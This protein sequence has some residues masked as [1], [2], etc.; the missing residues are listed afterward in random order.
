MRYQATAL[1]PPVGG[2]LVV[3][4]AQ[5]TL[6]MDIRPACDLKVRAFGPC[7]DAIAIT[8]SFIDFQEL[9]KNSRSEDGDTMAWMMPC[10]AIRP[11]GGRA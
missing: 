10:H 4:Q 7:H 3:S 9:E 6:G 2:G 11:P 8:S 1:P 5:C